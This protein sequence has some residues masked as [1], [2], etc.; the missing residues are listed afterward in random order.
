[1]EK[2]QASWECS[3][4]EWVNE[5]QS[6][7]FCGFEIQQLQGGG[8]KLWQPSYNQDLIEKHEITGEESAPCPKVVHGDTEVVQPRVLQ[9]AQMFTGELQWI[10]SRTR[11][12]L[13]YVCGL[14]SRLQH[15]LPFAISRRRGIL[16]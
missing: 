1:M 13:A 7:R 6:M 15:R 9:Q 10:Q 3:Q 12:D 16:P 2:L 8:L 5:H 14:M 11:P 4:P